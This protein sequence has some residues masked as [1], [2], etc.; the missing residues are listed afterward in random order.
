MTREKQFFVLVT[1]ILADS[2]LD[3]SQTRVCCMCK[4]L[5]YI[6]SKYL[7]LLKLSYSLKFTQDF[8]SALETP[9]KSLNPFFQDL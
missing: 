9:F 4:L 7:F 6:H 1:Q 2:F 5:Q 8:K 3:F